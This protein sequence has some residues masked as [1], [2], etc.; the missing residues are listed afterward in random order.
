[1]KIVVCYKLVPD[2]EKIQFK[3]GAMPDLSA[4]E[5]QIS[6]YD[7]C[8]IEAAS[9]IAE[10]NAD[11]QL[12]ALTAGGDIVE[13]SKLKK[14]L[15]SRG[16]QE[17]YAVKNEGLTFADSYAVAKVLA[18]AI[19]KIGDVSLVVFGEG[20]GDIYAQQVGNIVG[21]L[22]GWST[23]NAVSRLELADEGLLVERSLED[24]TETLRLSLPAA[25]SV[26]SNICLPRLASMKEI[27]KAGKKPSTILELD[28]LGT[29]I[30]ASV[31]TLQL[32]AKSKV[33]RDCTIV[34]AD[35]DGIGR[36]ALEIRKML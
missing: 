4:C 13:N 7:L 30:A 11:Y 32:A 14:S 22:L 28:E 29:E 12:L 10:Q 35:D 21:N 5:W 1:M 20:S 24:C 23:L 16:P 6:Q 17:M 18:A 31:E 26:T 25:I 27:L 34:A 19:E 8:A 15:L 3:K 2:E 36:L 9:K 33:E